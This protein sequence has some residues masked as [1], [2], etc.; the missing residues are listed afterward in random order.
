[1][2]HSSASAAS[3]TSLQP[4]PLPTSLFTCSHFKGLMCSALSPARASEPQVSVMWHRL[5]KRLS[6]L[7]S[8][9]AHQAV[10]RGWHGQGEV[11]RVWQPSYVNRGGISAVTFWRVRSAQGDSSPREC[12]RGCCCCP[13]PAPGWAQFTLVLRVWVWVGC[14]GER[15]QY[16]LLRLWGSQSPLERNELKVRHFGPERG[17]AP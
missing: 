5:P 14:R 12:F 2:S 6:G 4:E 10:Y 9:R 7:I 1:M 17:R 16:S 3:E 13:V 11:G 15:W 8:T